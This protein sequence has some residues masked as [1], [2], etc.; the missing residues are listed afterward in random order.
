[1]A[2]PRHFLGP[3]LL[4]LRTR[5]IATPRSGR[6]LVV[7]ALAG[8]ASHA[9]NGPAWPKQHE[10]EADGGESLAPHTARAVVAAE[11][12]EEE[13]AKPAATSAAPAAAPEKKEAGAA[14]AVAPANA[15]IDE[16]ITTEDIVIEIDD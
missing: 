5:V 15:T 9:A 13:P 3:R 6:F 1:M 16:T 14:P 10:A 4:A 8:C 11:K 12:A 7:V 2:A